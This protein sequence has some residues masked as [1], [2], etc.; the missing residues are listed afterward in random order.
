MAIIIIRTILVFAVLL[1]SLRMMGKRQLS[2]LELSE[3]VVAI[4]ISDLAAQPLQDI[5]IPIINGL[6]PVVVLL[7]CELLISGL[8]MKYP[9]ARQALYGKPSMLVVNGRIDQTEMRRNRFT[10]DELY[11]ELRK[12]SIM[13]ISI[14]KYAILETGGTLNVIEFPA[15]APVTPSQLGI[16]VEDA[17]SPVIL[18]NDGR[19]MTKNL[20]GCGKDENWLSRELRRRGAGAAS[21]VYLMSIDALGRIYYAPRQK[22]RKA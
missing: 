18:I 2:E 13:D 21:E 5:G 3:L 15:E 16:E 4:L 7:C 10:L 11:E 6:I 9:K 17:G 8:T 20:V 22:E 1:F 14:V 12:Q 19:V